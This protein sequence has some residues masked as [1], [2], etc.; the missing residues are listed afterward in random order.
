VI[1]DGRLHNFFGFAE[2]YA[3]VGQNS[4]LQAKPS[5]VHFSGFQVGERITKTL[6]SVMF[7]FSARLMSSNFVNMFV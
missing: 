5:V 7:Y 4:I 2:I 6:V 1:F 3:K